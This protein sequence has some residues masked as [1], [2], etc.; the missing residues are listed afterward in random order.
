MTITRWL[1]VLIL[2]VLVAAPAVAAPPSPPGFSPTGQPSGFE[3]TGR[4]YAVDGYRGAKWGMTTMQLRQAVAR[5]FPDAK[6]GIDV[7]D[8][9]TH[10]VM[11]VVIVPH[12]APG[13]GPMAITYLFGASTGRLFH[14]NLDWQADKA[15]AAD[16]TALTAAGSKIV[17]N[18]LG[19][20]WKLLSVA[21]GI[22]AGPNAL[23]LF[24]AAGQ[25]GGNVEV[26]L[27]GVGYSLRT[28]KGETVV[29]PPPPTP[30]QALLHVAFSQSET[31]ADVY[32][33]KPGEF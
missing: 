4:T 24:A 29:L 20:Y 8:P 15:T 19:Y 30:S 12:L 23:I 11:I 2:S 32:A 31:P 10:A 14:I 7:I 1:A 25:A 21:R 27:Q 33:I 5:D 9:V 28:I 18:F 22:P 6:I 3:V 17:E 13:P 26:L 16:Q